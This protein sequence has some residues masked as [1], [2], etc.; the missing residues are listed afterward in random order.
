MDDSKVDVENFFG[1]SVMSRLMRADSKE[2]V[3]EI[4]NDA[5]EDVVVLLKCGLELRYENHLETAVFVYEHVLDVLDRQETS[6][7]QHALRILAH[8]SIATAQYVN[9][10]YDSMTLHLQKALTLLDSLGA[11]DWNACAN[12]GKYENLGTWHSMKARVV[13]Q[14]ANVEQRLSKT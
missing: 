6:N 4:L 7:F 2:E 12:V 1:E 13:S 11:E 10:K 8:H 14:F 3:Y 5:S 9:K